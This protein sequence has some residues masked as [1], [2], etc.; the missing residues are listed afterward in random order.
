MGL[1]LAVVELMSGSSI[2]NYPEIKK[3]IERLLISSV[4]LWLRCVM[5]GLI[6]GNEV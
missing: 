1:Y 2:L 3:N 4:T 5:Y 6:L